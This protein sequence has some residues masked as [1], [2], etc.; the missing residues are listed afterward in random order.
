MKT[1]N[2]RLYVASASMTQIRDMLQ[3]EPTGKL[4]VA[5][6]KDGNGAHFYVSDKSHNILGWKKR[7]RLDKRTAVKSALAPKLLGGAVSNGSTHRILL[8]NDQDI[9]YQ[10]HGDAL[11]AAALLPE[12]VPAAGRADHLPRAVPNFNADELMKHCD[13]L[14]KT[15]DP[16]DISAHLLTAHQMLLSAPPALGLTDAQQMKMDVS[17][18]AAAKSLFANGA[19]FDESKFKKLPEE[20][21]ANLTR[22]T[23]SEPD[24]GSPMTSSIP[25]LTQL[26]SFLELPSESNEIN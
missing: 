18:R 15:S 26:K 11:D 3:E 8:V 17:F 4:R 20:A 13:Q 24:D 16:V 12:P 5:N 10:T 19:K 9:T 7:E 6:A 2:E 21:I 25:A 14:Q 1:T 22:L 23:A